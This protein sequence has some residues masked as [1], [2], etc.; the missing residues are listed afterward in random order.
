MVDQSS[1]HRPINQ[2]TA[3]REKS[4]DGIV[5]REREVLGRYSVPKPWQI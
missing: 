1:D 2:W 3:H 5:E 4:S